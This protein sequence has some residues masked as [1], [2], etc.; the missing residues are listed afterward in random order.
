MSVPLFP[1]DARDGGDLGSDEFPNPT[2]AHYSAADACRREWRRRFDRR[3]RVTDARDGELDQRPHRDKQVPVLREALRDS[4][5]DVVA[6]DH[7]SDEARAFIEYARPDG[8]SVSRG[9]VLVT[10]AFCAP[11]NSGAMFRDGVAA[12]DVTDDA[13]VEWAILPGHA[14]HRPGSLAETVLGRASTDGVAGMD[15]DLD[16]ADD[17]DDGDAK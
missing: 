7:D 2:N 5:L 11:G 9:I 3:R 6:F 1:D 4:C 15:L 14:S 13:T 10:A 17:G 8:V 16:D 12:A